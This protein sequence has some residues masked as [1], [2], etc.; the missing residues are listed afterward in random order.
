MLRL[1]ALLVAVSANS[2]QAGLLRVASRCSSTARMQIP[3]QLEAWGMDELLWS[4]VE[5]KRNL[6]K[7]V[8]RGEE[9]FARHRI[10]RLREMLLDSEPQQQTS[11][12]TLV[13]H[14]VAADELFFE[15]SCPAELTAERTMHVMLPDGREI[16]VQVPD[17]IAAGDVFLVGPVAQVEA[18]AT[19]AETTQLGVAVEEVAAE[20]L[21]AQLTAGARAELA[22]DKK[23][24]AMKEAAMVHAID[25]AAGEMAAEM[26]TTESEEA[27]AESSP[28][29]FSTA[30]AGLIIPA[31]RAAPRR[32]G[33][34]ETSAIEAL[35]LATQSHSR[36]RAIAFLQEVRMAV[37][38][39]VGL[40]ESDAVQH[41]RSAVKEARAVEELA[42]M[43]YRV[44][45]VESRM[46]EMAKLAPQRAPAGEE[47]GEAQGG[48]TPKAK[49]A[50][51]DMKI[52]SPSDLMEIASPSDLMEIACPAELTADRTVRL[53]LPDGREFD[54]QVPQSVKPGEIFLVS[55]A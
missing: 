9:D 32:V 53:L 11:K 28:T 5:N 34:A 31:Q 39:S 49:A 10:A 42:L 19:A 23:T 21:E 8:K 22:I 14:D 2:H 17:D 3:P 24:T 47:N 45:A 12:S 38:G 40:V 55:L 48:E 16:H 46:A 1:S 41:A 7:L 35:Q 4:K 51:P 52:A 27:E 43:R 44:V 18:M 6:R 33:C 37:G 29:G 50:A 26:E 13:A 15:V 25:D 20:G 30:L 54:V 36:A